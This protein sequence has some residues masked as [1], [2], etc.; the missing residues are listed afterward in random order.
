MQNL[1]EQLNLRRNQIKP[2]FSYCLLNINTPT[3]SLQEP[4]INLER[5]EFSIGHTKRRICG[6]I[7]QS[8]GRAI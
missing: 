4:N 8:N 5:S 7:E 1:I 2:E 6:R 3:L